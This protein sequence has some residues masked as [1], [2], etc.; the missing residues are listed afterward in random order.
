[1]FNVTLQYD[2]EKMLQNLRQQNDLWINYFL[3]MIKN[4]MKIIVLVI[5]DK[6]ILS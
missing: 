2:F 3:A 5:C 4:D 1:M 6:K